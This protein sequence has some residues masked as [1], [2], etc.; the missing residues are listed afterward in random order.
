MRTVRIR[1]LQSTVALWYLGIDSELLFVG[2]A[3]TTEAG[4][5]SRRLG[6]EWTNY[7]R[8]NPW[9]MLDADLSLSRARFSDD[10]PAGDEIPG[11]LGRVISA[12]VAFE[13]RTRIFG[14]LR[15]RHFGPRP[16]IENGAVR[17]RSTTLWNGEIGYRVS[18]GA[19]GTEVYNLFD[20][21]ASDIDYFYASRLPGEPLDGVDDI[22]THP[23]IPRTARVALLVSF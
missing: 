2:D 11:A 1:G 8:L 14:S 12:G 5:P 15:V 3:G 19:R 23:A 6:L 20:A 4:R 16:L 7:A 18:R 9:L 13:P 22:H 10:D 17:S 21:K